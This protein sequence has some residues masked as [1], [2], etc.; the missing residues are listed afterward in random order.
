ML[1]TLSGTFEERVKTAALAGI[2]N[3]ELLDEYT[4]WSDAAALRRAKRYIDSFGMI[5]ETVSATRNGSARPVSMVNPGDRDNFLV[6]LKAAIRIAQDLET[7]YIILTSGDE[8]AGQTRDEQYA[9]MLEGAKRAVDLAAAAN[10]T[11]IVEP[12]NNKIDHKGV[13]LTTCTEGVKLVKEVDSAHLRL[14]FNV[15][16]EQVQQGNVTATL[17][18]ALEYT[19]LVHIADAPGRDDPG[20][21]SIDF[22]EV[23][24]VISKGG[25]SHTVGMEYLPKGDPV[26]SLRTAVDSFRAGVNERGGL[27]ASTEAGFV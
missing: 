27:A 7:P 3:V 8:V 19:A 26:G 10:V 4:K 21:G 11:L 22:R 16:H 17:R 2:Q 14:L 18:D 5:A 24:R 12:L 6:N 25:Y 20:T 9:S 13:Y 15:Y 23:Y 1:W